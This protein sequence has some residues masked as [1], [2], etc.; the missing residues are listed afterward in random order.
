M[1][2][3]NKNNEFDELQENLNR[4][5][6]LTKRL[7]LSLANKNNDTDYSKPNQELYYKAASKYFSEMLSNPSRLI[8]NQVK[9]YKSTLQIWSDAQKDF[10][11]QTENEA[12]VSDRRF[13]EST[14]ENNPYFKMIKNQYITSSNIIEQTVNSIEGLSKPDKKQIS[15]FTKQMVDFFSPTNFL[16]TNPEAI[17]EAIETKGK[18]LVDGLENLVND[19]EKNDGE[20]NVTLTD[21]NAFEV[22]KNIAQSKGSVIFQNELFQLIHYEPVSKKCYSTPLLIIPPWINKFYILDLKHENSFIQF[23]LKKNLSVFVISWVNPGTEHKNVSFEDYIDK[24]LLKAADIIKRYCRQDQINTIGYCI[25]GTL[26]ASTLAYLNKKNIKF[27]KSSTFFTTLT[28]FEDPGD[29]SI[30]VTDEYL[31][32]INKQIEKFGYMEGSFLAKTFSFLRSN[33]LVY[34][35]AIKSYLMGKKPPPFDLLYWN[36]DSTNLPGVMALEYLENFYQKNMLSKGK[37][38]VFD[39]IVSLEDINLPIFAVATHTDHIAPWK[40]SFFGLNKTTGEK[41][42]IL[43]GSGHIAGIINPENSDKYGYWTNETKME[44]INEWFYKAK[45]NEGSWWSEWASWIQNNSGSLDETKFNHNNEFQIIENAPGSYVK[46][47][48]K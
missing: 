22:G 20:L 6:S 48:F 26:L 36:S 21:D 44:D 30:F 45:K 29:L 27:I 43:A 18:S 24:G 37:L 15:F 31:S 16:G 14:W 4:I 41:K 7:V 19:L 32:S 39:E 25:G 23:C 46:K 34:G 40:S 35:P 10:L 13:K 17:K 28:D 38:K 9:F 33:D 1:N 47:K 5:D 2:D 11:N 12:D 42:F 3:D 8:E